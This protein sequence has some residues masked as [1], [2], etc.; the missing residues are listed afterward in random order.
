MI[1]YE[2]SAVFKDVLTSRSVSILIYLCGYIFLLPTA[3]NVATATPKMLLSLSPPIAYCLCVLN[4]Y[5]LDVILI[6]VNVR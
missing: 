5:K 4:M 6:C 2:N 1:S 3:L